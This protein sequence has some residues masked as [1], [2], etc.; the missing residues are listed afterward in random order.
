[1]SHKGIQGQVES[2]RLNKIKEYKKENNS[3]VK[4][5]IFNLG[6]ILLFSFI[7]LMMS[8]NT[9]LNSDIKFSIILTVFSINFTFATEIKDWNEYFINDKNINSSEVNIIQKLIYYI[10]AFTIVLFLLCI[11]GYLFMFATN[12]SDNTANAITI[13]VII[14]FAVSYTVRLILIEKR[15]LNNKI[16]ALK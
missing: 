14:L 4:L 13:A 10:P 3:I 6:A 5:Y 16:K 9:K 8:L 15:K 1:M 12:I 2:E 7:F 11:F